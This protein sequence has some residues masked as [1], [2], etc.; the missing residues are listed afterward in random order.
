MK[1]NEFARLVTLIEGL[2]K[3]LD[4]AQVK[5]VLRVVN[6]LLAGKLYKNIREFTDIPE[7]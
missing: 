2:K 1:V 5:E 4:I 3:E 6:D 7:C